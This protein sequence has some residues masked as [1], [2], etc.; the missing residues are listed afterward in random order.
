MSTLGLE[1]FFDVNKNPGIANANLR[2]YDKKGFDEALCLG[3]YLDAMQAC[4]PLRLSFLMAQGERAIPPLGLLSYSMTLTPVPNP[5]RLRHGV[6]GTSK[7]Q[8]KKFVVHTGQV[9]SK[10]IFTYILQLL[11]VKILAKSISTGVASYL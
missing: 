9:T 4:S 1:V 8:V 5:N 6:G 10:P 7:L 3:H 11:L 2:L